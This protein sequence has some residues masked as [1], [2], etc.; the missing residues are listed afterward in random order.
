MHSNNAAVSDDDVIREF[1]RLFRLYKDGRV[2]RF[3]GTET[4]PAG[5]HS[6]TGV[7]SKDV[8]IDPDTGVAARLYLPAAASGEKLPLLIYIHGGA[9]CIGSPFIPPYHHHLNAVVSRANVV[10]LSV[11]YRLAPE[12]PLPTAYDDAWAAIQWASAHSARNGPEPWLNDHADFQRVYFAGDS[13][14]ANIAHNMAMRVGSGSG[15]PS[16]NLDG[17]VLVHPYF[18]NGEKDELIE[19]LFPTR[20]NGMDDPRLNPAKDPDLAGLGC[21]RAVV[22]VAEKDELRER[23]VSYY[24][25][26]KKSGWSGVV[27]M[28]ETEGEGHVF[29]LFD[30]TKEKV[31]EL[32]KRFVSFLKDSHSVSTMDSSP[33][34]S[35]AHTNKEEEEEEKEEEL[36]YDLSPIMKVYKDGRIVRLAGEDVAPP[37]VDPATGVESKDVVISGHDDGGGGGGVSVR[38][39]IP[40]LTTPDLKLPLFVYFHGGAFC[41]ET[42]F[43]P[44]YHNYL[45]S[46]VSRA[47]VVGVSVHYRRAPEHPVPAAH[48]DSW[49][50]L[51]WVASHSAGNGPDEWLNRHGDLTKVFLSGDSAGANIA[52]HMAIRVGSETLPGLTLQGIALVH[53][54]FWGAERIRAESDRAEYAAKVDGLWKFACPTASGSDDPLINPEKDPK[55]GRLGCKRILVCVAEKDLLKDRGWYYKEILERNGFGGEI[56]VMETKEEDHVFHMLKPTCENA[57]AMLDRIVSFIKKD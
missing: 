29:H 37:G 39:F 12:H 11:H 26:V 4:T 3:L 31:R 20:S 32:V 24:E 17:L 22:M 13:A 35:A 18:S 1:P 27:D 15:S 53:P 33:P 19:F 57:V 48:E 49:T 45:N 55:L 23:G 2:H 40:K 14:G 51:E 7:Q 47:N 46:V 52:H 8:T 30:P 28:V 34:S 42:P 21:R 54:Y 25:A 36:A 38:L 43:S 5:L 16:L 6:P 41:I 10:A 9:F 50:A 56:E 44:N